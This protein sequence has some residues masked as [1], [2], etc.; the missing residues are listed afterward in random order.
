MWDY[1]VNLK[2][3]KSTHWLVF[4]AS[5]AGIAIT[6]KLGYWQFTRA[7]E[8]IALQADMQQQMALPALDAQTLILTKDR[9]L[10]LHRTVN[11]SGRWLAQ[12]TLFLDNRQINGQPGFYVLT[13][14]EFADET[15]GLKKTIVVQ[16]GW[17]A[18]NFLDRQQLPRIKTSEESVRIVGR[19]ALAPSKL[20]EFKGAEQGQIRQNVSIAALSKEFK[21]DLLD[22]TLLQ[23][24]DVDSVKLND[25]MLRNWPKPN[26]GVEKHYGYMFQ[27]WALSALI[28]ILFVWF[29]I[30]RPRIH[31]QVKVTHD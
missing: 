24:D 18:R 21:I 20:Y 14:F 12:Y 30:I 29:Q 31:S 7:N 11:L 15:S 27:W 28:A 19:L 10:N 23:I 17:V 3:L 9:V 22:M 6:A 26:M 1:G 4:L 5:V 2:T 13:P 25:G 8:K 16:R